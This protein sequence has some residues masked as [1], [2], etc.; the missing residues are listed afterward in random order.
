ME[1]FNLKDY[2]ILRM[3]NAS[4][5]LRKGSETFFITR[6]VFNRLLENPTFPAA[7]ME[8]KDKCGVERKWIA[9]LSIF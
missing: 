2:E 3:N 6:N 1:S 8:K 7:I 9:T 5:A 4:L